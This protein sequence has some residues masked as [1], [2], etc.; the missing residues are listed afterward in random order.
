MN[1]V[2]VNLVQILID[3]ISVPDRTIPAIY[4]SR[5]SYSK[6]ARL[7]CILI[8]FCTDQSYNLFNDRIKFNAE[9]YTPN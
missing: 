6:R 3:L 8:R 5:I 1:Y 4:S 7:F 9:P 2:R